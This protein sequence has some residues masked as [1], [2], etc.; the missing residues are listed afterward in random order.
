MAVAVCGWLFF[1]LLAEFGEFAVGVHL[2]CQALHGAF[3]D[4]VFDDAVHV[5]PFLADGAAPMHLHCQN[6]EGFLE[7]VQAMLQVAGAQH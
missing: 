2:L 4:V 3:E 6:D 7:V 5:C 1:F